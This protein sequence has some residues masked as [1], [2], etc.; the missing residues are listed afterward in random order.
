MTEAQAIEVHIHNSALGHHN[1][2]V[3]FLAL[4][5]YFAIAL[6]TQTTSKRVMVPPSHISF[7]SP[8]QSESY[9]IPTNDIFTNIQA[10]HALCFKH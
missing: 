8:S 6:C 7:L 4:L 10:T 1:F 2:L 5:I 9:S 3:V